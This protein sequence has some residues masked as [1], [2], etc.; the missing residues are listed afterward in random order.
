[1]N[2]D[3]KDVYDR[4]EDVLNNLVQKKRLRDYGMTEAQIAEFADSVFEKQ[5]RLLVNNFV[6]FTRDQIFDIYKE[7][8]WV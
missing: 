8:Y 1:M 6:P 5:Q 7:L 3:E 4:I 2:C